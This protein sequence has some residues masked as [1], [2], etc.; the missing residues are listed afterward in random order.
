MK[1][2][3][4]FL[5]GAESTDRECDFTASSAS[6]SGAGSGKVKVY[7]LIILDRSGSMSCLR[8]SAVSGFNETLSGIRK[9]QEQYSATQDQFVSLVTFCSCTMDTVYDTVPVADVRPLTLDDYVPCCCTPLFDAMGFSLTKLDKTVGDDKSAVVMVTVITDGM[10]NDSREYDGRRIVK[11]VERL[12]G[13]G[14]I[15]TYMGANQDVEA[16]ARS[17]SIDHA[18]AFNYDAEGMRG[19]MRRDGHMRMNVFARIDNICYNMR[20]DSDADMEMMRAEL[21]K[22]AGQAFDEY[23]AGDDEPQDKGK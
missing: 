13:K 7:N 15:F 14:W 4:D 18:A 1:S 2:L 21:E 16:V 10:E 8:E 11:L 20:P 17:L 6:A 23:D 19:T 22:T 9:A 12:K 3:K 5:V